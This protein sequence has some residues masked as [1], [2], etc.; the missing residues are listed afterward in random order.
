MATT[1]AIEW[2]DKTYNPWIG[3]T[4][5]SSGCANCY[6]ESLSLQK[7]FVNE[8]GPKGTRHITQTAQSVL[9]WNQEAIE[10]GT[11]YTVFCASLGDVFEKNPALVQHRADLWR[12]I[13]QTPFLDWMLL[14]K[15]PENIASMLPED[16]GSGYPHVSLMTSTEDQACF[17]KRV[18]V[19]QK[20][21]SKR[22]ALSVEPLLGP[23]SIPAGG[24]EGIDLVIV[25]GES[26]KDARPMNP[27]WVRELRDA[28]A[29]EGVAFFFKQWGNWTPD[30]SHAKSDLSNVAL[31]TKDNPKPQLVNASIS[32]ELRKPMVEAHVG[33]VVYHVN[34]K[35]LTGK[36]LD[37]V[38]HTNHPYM[39]SRNAS[40][41][42]TA[43]L[44]KSEAKELQKLEATVADGVAQFWAVGLALRQIRDKGLYR[45]THKT[46]ESYCLEKWEISRPEAYRQIGAAEVM[47]D[48]CIAEG[49]I[50]PKSVA[51]TRPLMKLKTAALRRQVWSVV[52]SQ[53]K[54]VITAEVVEAAVCKVLHKET[55]TT[56]VTT[57]VAA[58]KAE[59]AL[60]V[61]AE[62]ES[63]EA[64]S[65]EA[66]D[67][68]C[69]PVRK[70][71][72]DL[73]SELE[74]ELGNSMSEAVASTLKKLREAAVEILN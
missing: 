5:V 45:E 11:R 51:Q 36:T 30:A 3:C 12:L 4:K 35:K 1:T 48:L 47:E 55:S 54:V 70:E 23:I 61:T 15:R 67:T 22:R 52:K 40:T 16:W 57:K 41:T 25:G 38:V 66:E 24:L 31:F 59:P 63:A 64:E 50:A 43:P 14:T 37:G 8:W 34:N 17:D 6:A 44:S 74:S 13:K 9:E 46:F 56:K 10:A 60:V 20:V 29:R 33:Q 72:Q 49:E 27:E 19:L 32:E 28:C 2:T 39:T 58:L 7:G 53:K 73:I 71:V 69:F 65:A 18:P 26:G 21:K 68:G 62:V 42:T